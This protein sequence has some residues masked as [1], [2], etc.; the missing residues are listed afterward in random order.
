M[1]RI[2]RTYQRPTNATG[3]LMIWRSGFGHDLV[4]VQSTKEILYAH[5][6]VKFLTGFS[7]GQIGLIPE[8]QLR[9]TTRQT[10]ERYDNFVASR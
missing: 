1:R 3:Q 8:S 9:D 5:I 2:R 10:F 6:S 7:V 4:E